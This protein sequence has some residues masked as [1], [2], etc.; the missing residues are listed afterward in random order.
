MIVRQVPVDEITIPPDRFREA[1]MDAVDDLAT[2]FL[3]Y[4]QLQPIIIEAKDRVLLAGLHRILA[5]KENG[6]ATIAAV[7]RDEADEL[8]LRE[9]ELEEN[10]RRRQM[11]WLEEQKAIAKLHEIRKARDPNWN[12]TL[13]QQVAGVARQADVSEAVHLTKMV[14]LFPEIAEAKSKNQAMS[15]AKAKA[16][17]ILRVHDVKSHEVDYADIERKLV[18]GDSVEVIKG[19]DD[20]IF[21]AIITDPPFGISYDDRKT[22]TLGSLTSY[23]DSDDSYR[24]LLSMAPDLYRVLK[25]DGWLIWFLGISWYH[26]AKG[27]FREAGFLVDEVPIIWNRSKGKCF[28]ARPDR[29]FARGY[30]IAL[31][32]IK[33]DPQMIQRGKSNVIEV[34]PVGN[35][36]RETLVERPVDLYAE[37]IRRLTVPKERVADFFAGSGSCLAAA[38]SLGRDYWGCELDA[39]RRAYAI[40]KIKAHTPDT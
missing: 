37:L 26:E 21:H 34:M 7:H 5:A 1:D 17:S 38:A 12:Q 18:H 19:L 30:D 35:S 32:C 33:G 20:E 16:K 9:M 29:Y 24:R 2:S 23:E 27:V 25:P 14:E 11:T 15:W 40:K 22:G 31:H 13:T 4:G 28:T 6:W 10:I 8:F 36:E 3:K 39:E